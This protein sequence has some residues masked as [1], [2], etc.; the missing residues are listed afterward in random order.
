MKKIQSGVLY[1]YKK[2]GRKNL[3]WKKTKNPYKIWISEIMLQQTRVKTVIPYFKR[4]ISFFPNIKKLSQSSIDEVF[5]L[6]SG[7]GY[8]K[9][10]KN[11]HASSKIIQKKYLGVF[12]KKF[13]ELIELPGIGKSTAHAI[14]SFAFQKHYPILDANVKKVL[15]RFYD[16]TKFTNKKKMEDFFWHKAQMNLPKYESHH[17]NQ[18]M[19][20][21]GSELCIK[22]PKCFYCPLNQSCSSNKK[23][24]FST[25]LNR[26]KKIKKKRIYL[27]ILKKNQK[28]WL[29]RNSENEIYAGLFNFPEIKGTKEIEKYFVIL[30][31]FS[32]RIS[33]KKIKF[34]LIVLKKN[35]KYKKFINDKKGI[36][37]DIYENELIGISSIVSKIISN[38]KKNKYEEKNFLCIF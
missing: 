6:W 17:F 29:Q 27:L 36:W 3:P 22:K 1:W 13:S 11:I 32:K 16:C 2:F 12:P 30:D 31:S 28:V 38:I 8:Y 19:M 35:K 14:L 21:I 20:D 23:K 10:A 9:R 37:Y 4:F 26:K 5:F 34:S 15:Y 33:N 7:L 25:I 18:A 24:I